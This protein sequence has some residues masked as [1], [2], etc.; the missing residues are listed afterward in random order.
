MT[1]WIKVTRVKH[2]L[3]PRSLILLENTVSAWHAAVNYY[4]IHVPCTNRRASTSAHA[5]DTQLVGMVKVNNSMQFTYVLLSCYACTIFYFVWDMR[6]PQWN[7]I[8]NL[9]LGPA[10]RCYGNQSNICNGLWWFDNKLPSIASGHI[11]L[12]APFR[13]FI[14]YFNIP[15]KFLL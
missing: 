13:F 6:C 10:K 1:W 12:S 5:S 9:D 4:S 3:V 2:F 11:C 15:S 7:L 14:N 8:Y